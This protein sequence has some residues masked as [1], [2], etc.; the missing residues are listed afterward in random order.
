MSTPNTPRLTPTGPLG[1]SSMCF[2][3]KGRSF[4]ASRVVIEPVGRERAD[5]RHGNDPGDQD[6]EA[7]LSLRSFLAEHHR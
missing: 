3:E 6:P 1:R 5:E 4:Q 2:G 7:M